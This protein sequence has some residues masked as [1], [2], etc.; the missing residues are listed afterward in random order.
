MLRTERL[1]H[2]DVGVPLVDDVDTCSATAGL[3][4]LVRSSVTPEHREAWNF[5][6]VVVFRKPSLT[7]QMMAVSILYLCRNLAHTSGLSILFLTD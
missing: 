5:W 7:N 2:R 1:P 6:V 3:S 4:R